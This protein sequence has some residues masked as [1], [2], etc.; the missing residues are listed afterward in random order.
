MIPGWC[1]TPCDARGSRC[2]AEYDC[3]VLLGD[4]RSTS[5]TGGCEL[6]KDSFR[7]LGMV[8]VRTVMVKTF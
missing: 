8:K 6:A 2:E 1:F 5:D 3:C 7:D 4:E